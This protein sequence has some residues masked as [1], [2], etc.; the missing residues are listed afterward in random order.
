MANQAK[1]INTTGLADLLLEPR[2]EYI[3]NFRTVASYQFALYVL[4][5]VDLFFESKQNPLIYFKYTTK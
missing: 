1:S 3:H 5:E 2:F 4:S